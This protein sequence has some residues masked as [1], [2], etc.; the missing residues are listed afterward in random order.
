MCGS[1]STLE[2]KKQEYWRVPAF[3]IENDIANKFWFMFFQKAIAGPHS[4]IQ[5]QLNIF[6]TEL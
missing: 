5:N 4:Q 2:K 1:G 3:K 6:K